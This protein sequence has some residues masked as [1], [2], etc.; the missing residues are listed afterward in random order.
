M[1]SSNTDNINNSLISSPDMVP[2]SD[3]KTLVLYFTIYFVLAFITCFLCMYINHKNK[4]GTVLFIVLEIMLVVVLI[5]RI[6][7]DLSKVEI[8][9]SYIKTIFGILLALFLF[10]LPAIMAMVISYKTYDKNKFNYYNIII[11]IICTI[12]VPSILLAMI[13]SRLK[14]TSN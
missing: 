1:S 2:R 11:G 12:M 3:I 9:K 10:M 5:S 6:Q 7:K 13:L 14:I 8:T 4:Y